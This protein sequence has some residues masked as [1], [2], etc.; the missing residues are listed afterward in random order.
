MG[1]QWGSLYANCTR[2]FLVIGDPFG[3]VLSEGG[4]THLGAWALWE[5]SAPNSGGWPCRLT[6][7]RFPRHFT[8]ACHAHQVCSRTTTHQALMDK[9]SEDS[10]TSL[11]MVANIP[12]YQGFQQQT[13]TQILQA[14]VQKKLICDHKCDHYTHGRGLQN[15]SM[16][17]EPDIGGYLCTYLFTG[18]QT[19]L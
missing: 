9:I 16:H 1:Y 12:T 3:G 18:S 11:T 10:Q 13:R 8:M 14:G 5:N 6:R 15:T 7:S 17:S 4:A 2:S 19:T